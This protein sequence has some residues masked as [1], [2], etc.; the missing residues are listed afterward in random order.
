M[1][2]QYVIMPTTALQSH[3]GT[4]V[5][6][7]DLWLLH[8]GFKNHKWGSLVKIILLIKSCKY[9]KCLFL[10]RA[11][12]LQQGDANFHVGL[13]KTSSLKHVNAFI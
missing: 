9:H 13:K 4:Y 6:S 3:F 7:C 12:F 2:P 8:L 11:Y 10:H 1:R 5:K